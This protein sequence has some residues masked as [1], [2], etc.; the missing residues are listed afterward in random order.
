MV[1]QGPEIAIQQNEEVLK[2]MNAWCIE[3]HGA[4]GLTQRCREST[5]SMQEAE[6]QVGTS[7]AARTHQ[8]LMD[9]SST[10]KYCRFLAAPFKGA[11]KMAALS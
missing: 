1:V 10:L 4:S 8:P 7:S 3:H 5:T 9:G 6:V 11:A 2:S